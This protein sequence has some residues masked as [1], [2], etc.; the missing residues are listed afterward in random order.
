MTLVGS[1]LRTC[2]PSKEVARDLISGERCKQETCSDTQYPGGMK[3]V[4]G[5]VC[6]TLFEDFAEIALDALECLSLRFVNA[7]RPGADHWEL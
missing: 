6:L 5:Y 3:N 2:R 1:K 4:Q 7:H